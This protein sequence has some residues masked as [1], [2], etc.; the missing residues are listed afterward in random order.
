LINLYITGIALED[1][2]IVRNTPI[3]P[4]DVL[5]MDDM[6][7][8]AGKPVLPNQLDYFISKIEK[9]NLATQISKKT[10]ELQAAIEAESG[11]PLSEKAIQQLEERVNDSV[12]QAGGTCAFVEDN[13]A[14]TGSSTRASQEAMAIQKYQRKQTLKRLAARK[15]GGGEKMTPAEWNLWSQNYDSDDDVEDVQAEINRNLVRKNLSG[16]TDYKGWDKWTE[17]G[18]VDFQYSAIL[19]E[20]R[21]ND[22]KLRTC[23]S[24]AA[25]IEKERGNA[26][27]KAGDFASAQVAYKAASVLYPSNATYHGNLAQVCLKL[28][29]FKETI[30]ACSCSIQCDGTQPK[31]YMRRAAARKGQFPTDRNET[32]KA[33][34]D[35][36]EARRYGVCNIKR[37]EIFQRM[38]Y[39]KRGG[40]NGCNS[41]VKGGKVSMDQKWREEEF[42]TYGM[43]K[44]SEAL[45]QLFV[46]PLLPFYFCS[47]PH[48]RPTTQACRCN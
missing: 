40:F 27:Y 45:C 11:T 8:F 12:M 19:E 15:R 29:M 36:K 38:K 32:I 16:Q 30:N 42:R 37:K 6:V 3:G 34:E 5:D 35:L 46:S 23:R 26:L 25:A 14:R 17:A 43:Y 2:D 31:Y 20:R 28:S 47:S 33:I 39:G 7:K 44:L 24:K 18:D 10:K 9:L 21:Q 22:A 48:L 41:N 4:G 1:D 13:A